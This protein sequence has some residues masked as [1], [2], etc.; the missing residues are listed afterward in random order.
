MSIAV[1]LTLWAAWLIWK[2]REDLLKYVVVVAAAMFL[3][4]T[5]VGQTVTST[6]GDGANW[7]DTTVGGWVKSDKTT[8]APAPQG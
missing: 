8:P 6:L 4:G 1:I 5:P 7:L 2:D 3:A